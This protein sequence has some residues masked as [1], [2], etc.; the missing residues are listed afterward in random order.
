MKTRS[1][2]KNY[3][4]QIYFTT[5]GLPPISLSWRQPLETHNHRFFLQLNSCGDSPYVTSP[6]TI[7]L[8]CLLWICL[9]FVKC[10][11]L[12]Y[13]M[14]LRNSPFYTTHKSSVSTAFA[15]QIMPILR[16]L[17]Y[18]GSLVIWTV[19]S[20]T[21]SKFKDSYIFCVWLHFLKKYR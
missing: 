15:D 6:L 7:R 21:T 1:S 10:M 8:V 2:A 19:V 12:T 18:N 4:S 20:L 11:Y 3:Q 16:I 13:S 14:L 9:A 17:C 5:G